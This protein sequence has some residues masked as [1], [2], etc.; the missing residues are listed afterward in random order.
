[1]KQ[2]AYDRI[3]LRCLITNLPNPVTGSQPVAALQM[4]QTRV[5][6]QDYF[7]GYLREA[8]GIT[9]GVVS[10]SDVVEG[11][12][13]GI[14]GWVNEADSALAS[15]ETLVIDTSQNGRKDRRSC[16][17]TTNEG[18]STLVEDQDIVTDGRDV[19]VTT[20]IAVIDTTPSTDVRVIGG[21]V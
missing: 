8:I 17:G 1:M 16:R 5:D 21:G 15:F 6:L 20:A 9:S 4:S 19:R 11:T 7:G 13:V 2:L 3:L 18:W 10:S 14:Q 12:W